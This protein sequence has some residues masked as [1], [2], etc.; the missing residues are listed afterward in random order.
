MLFGGWGGWGGWG[1]SLLTLL[2]S[3]FRI[4]QDAALRAVNAV[5]S[6]AGPRR[7]AAAAAALHLSR[8]CLCSG[9]RV[10]N[11]LTTW[12]LPLVIWSQVREKKNESV[13]RNLHTEYRLNI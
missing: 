2:H 3:H 9:S 11:V 10:S 6:L 4:V 5:P 8:A 13:W 7:Y 12:G 1:G